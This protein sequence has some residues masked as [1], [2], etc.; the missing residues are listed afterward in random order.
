MRLC[1][2]LGGMTLEEMQQRMSRAELKQWERFA[3]IDGLPEFNASFRAAVA[4]V[5]QAGI[6]GRS[7]KVDEFLD[8]PEKL[9]RRPVKAEAQSDEDMKAALGCMVGGT[10]GDGE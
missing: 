6:A 7:A 8:D 9:W 1:L 4:C 5:M 2:A 10:G 3:A